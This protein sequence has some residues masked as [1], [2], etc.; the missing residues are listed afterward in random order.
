MRAT[1]DVIVV[2][3]GPAGSCAAWKLAQ[4]GM[5]VAVLEKAALP[6][7]KVCGGGLVGQT[8]QW[9]PI[10]VRHVVE[11]KCYRARLDF[12]SSGLSF[13]TQRTIPVVSMTMRSEFDFALLSAARAE[14]AAI[15]ERC[16]VRNLSHHGDSITVITPQGPMRARFIVAADGVFSSV[17]RSMEWEDNRLLIPALEYEVTVPF[18]QVRR[19]EGIARFDFDVV[20]QGYAWVFPKRTHLSIGVLSMAK[21]RH[22]LRTAIAHYM[23][24]LGCGSAAGVERYGFV[25][26]VRPRKG[27]FAKKRVLLVGDA[28]GFADPVTGEG[29]SSAVRS[30]LLAAQSLIDGHL[31]KEAV[32]DTYHRV[33]T[34]AILPDLRAGR[35][36]ARFLYGYPHL[37]TWAFSRQGQRLCEIVTDV[38]A[39]TRRYRDLVRP[40]SLFRF[41]KF[42]RLSRSMN[43]P[44]Q[45]RQSWR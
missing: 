44:S 3:A 6:R 27:G 29:I 26:P 18:D 19:F 33:V 17:A 11:H 40:G 1:Y 24:L 5:A 4:A 39:G 37:R 34:K 35:M 10:D 12:L 15:H 13:T 2:G 45:V 30:G 8:M 28:A 16:F 7:Y 41:F 21:Q 23:D 20:P 43:R 42:R 38:M 32:E 14:G 9:L 36:L 31:Q 22:G 25:I